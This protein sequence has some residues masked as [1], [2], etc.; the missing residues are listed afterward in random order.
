MYLYV[1]PLFQV[2]IH[3]VQSLLEGK[4]CSLN[5]IPANPCATLDLNCMG[6][7]VKFMRFGYHV[8]SFAV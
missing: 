6:V 5:R 3:V 7:N 8:R 2:S 1:Y 4:I